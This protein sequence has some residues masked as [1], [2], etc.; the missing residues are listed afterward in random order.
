MKGVNIRLSAGLEAASPER[1]AGL[2]SSGKIRHEAMQFEATLLAVL[3]DQA[4]PKGSSSFGQGLSGAFARGQMSQELARS[5]ASNGGIGVARTIEHVL[6]ASYRS[7][8]VQFE[9]GTL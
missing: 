7:E 8:N 6:D 1:A 3:F 9:A 4:L 2:A 5:V